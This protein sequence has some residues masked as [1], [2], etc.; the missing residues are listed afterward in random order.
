M[1]AGILRDIVSKEGSIHINVESAG[2]YA[3][4][5]EPAA[6]LALRVCE[7]NGVDISDHIAKRID[8]NLINN[9]DLI[10]A[11]E[12]YHYEE[13]IC[14]YPE[15][16]GK[17]VLLGSM[18]KTKGIDSIPDPYGKGLEEFGQCFYQIRRLVER[19]YEE[20]IKQ[21]LD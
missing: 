4:E 21:G 6:P 2:V 20:V 3:C 13:I 19:L 1:A 5:G 7:N 17:I 12:P 18:E 10:V 11:M 14:S 15:K 9:S 8:E 16:E